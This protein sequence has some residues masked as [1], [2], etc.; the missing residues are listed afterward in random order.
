MQ[1]FI[2]SQELQTNRSVRLFGINSGFKEVRSTVAP[3]ATTTRSSSV[4]FHNSSLILSA[5]DDVE[6][7]I[8]IQSLNRSIEFTRVY[9]VQLD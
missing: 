6:P 7:A 1:D 9:C 2:N 8:Q 5:V 4:S 3:R